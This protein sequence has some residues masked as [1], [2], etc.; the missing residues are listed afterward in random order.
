MNTK[1]TCQSTYEINM[2]STSFHI[3]YWWR[4]WTF[5]MMRKKIS[6]QEKIKKFI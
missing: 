6:K 2:T 1:T 3:N 5:I 4:I